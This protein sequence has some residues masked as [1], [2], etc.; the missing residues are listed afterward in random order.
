MCAGHE[1]QSF[2]DLNVVVFFG[3]FFKKLIFNEVFR[4]TASENWLLKITAVAMS[5]IAD[6]PPSQ[7]FSLS[8]CAIRL[9]SFI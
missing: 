4:M 7:P 9:S 6:C 8:I 2:F 1:P 3:G 5:F